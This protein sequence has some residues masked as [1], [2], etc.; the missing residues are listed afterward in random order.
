MCFE[1]NVERPSTPLRVT[2]VSCCVPF[3][4]AQGDLACHAACPSTPL[5]VTWRVMLSGVEA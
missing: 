3:D 1:Y 2:G 5:R 4:S